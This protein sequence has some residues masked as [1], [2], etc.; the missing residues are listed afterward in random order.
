MPIETIILLL[1]GLHHLF[2]A[3]PYYVPANAN[4]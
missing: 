1:P 4:G 3:V 2:T